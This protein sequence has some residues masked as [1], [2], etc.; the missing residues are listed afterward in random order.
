MKI[1]AKQ[2]LAILIVVLG[3]LTASTAQLTDIFGPTATKLIVSISAILNSLL[4]GIMAVFTS[5]DN[6]V[7]DVQAMPGI[8]KIVVNERANTNLA[9]MAVDPQN[10]KIEATPSSVEMV[11]QT[12]R[13][14]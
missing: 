2:A 6:T 13:N 5:Q 12:A 9:S 11:N 14:G 8:E 7:R 10:T 1:N 3:V 4:A